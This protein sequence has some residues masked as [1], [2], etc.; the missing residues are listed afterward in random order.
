MVKANKKRQVYTVI[1]SD[2][3]DL[4]SIEFDSK[5][6]ALNFINSEC[7]LEDFSDEPI[8]NIVGLFKGKEIKLETMRQAIIFD[9]KDESGEE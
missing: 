2:S 4:Q 9:D 6:A 8:E 5:E 3:R 1:T 7:N